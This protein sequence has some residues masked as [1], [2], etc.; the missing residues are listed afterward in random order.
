[1][2]GISIFIASPVSKRPISVGF[3]GINW[4]R[5]LRPCSV[6][7]V[8]LFVTK[9]ATGIAAAFWALFL[10]LYPSLSLCRSL[11]LLFPSL[12]SSLFI[13]LSGSAVHLPLFLMAKW[14]ESWESAGIQELRQA[15]ASLSAASH[16]FHRS[17]SQVNGLIV[18]IQT[19]HF[20][21]IFLFKT[22][23]PPRSVDMSKP[24]LDRSAECLEIKKQQ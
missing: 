4:W 22:F 12:L 18:W 6:P 7:T 20:I 8:I 1:M 19:G 17:C 9:P 15:A 16:T 24:M 14:E 13:L 23:C 11:P 10:S 5:C 3:G 2:G 21:F